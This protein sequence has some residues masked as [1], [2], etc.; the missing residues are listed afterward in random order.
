MLDVLSKNGR[1]GALYELLY[2]D[3]CF[4]GGDN[5]KTESKIFLLKGFEGGKIHG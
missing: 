4:D 5:K 3:A 2:V 1:K